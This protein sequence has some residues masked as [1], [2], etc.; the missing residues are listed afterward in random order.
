MAR[1]ALGKSQSPRIHR[2]NL[3]GVRTGTLEAEIVTNGSYSPECESLLGL[4]MGSEVLGQDTQ[5]LQ[6][7][8]SSSVNEYVTVLETYSQ[9][10]HPQVLMPY[11]AHAGC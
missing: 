8:V 11:E 9:K 5:P 3:L 2:R 6:A 7:S 4:L 1:D 10:S